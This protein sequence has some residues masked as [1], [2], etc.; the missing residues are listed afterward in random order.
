M[1]GYLLPV[2]LKPVNRQSHPRPPII[3]HLW[4]CLAIGALAAFGGILWPPLLSTDITPETVVVIYSV[5][6]ALTT[7]VVVTTSRAVFARYR[8]ALEH[9]ASIAIDRPL[10]SPAAITTLNH[11][12]WI[13]AVVAAVALLGPM[14]YAASEW[15]MSARMGLAVGVAVAIS[16]GVWMVLAARTV[17]YTNIFERARVTAYQRGVIASHERAAREAANRRAGVLAKTLAGQ[18]LSALTPLSPGPTL[19]SRG[20]VAHLTMN[21]FYSRL[22][23]G[24]WVDGQQCEVLVTTERLVARTV[25]HGELSFWWSNLTAARAHDLGVE[26]HY[27]SSD[28]IS[29]CGPDTALI[30]VYASHLPRLTL[31]R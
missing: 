1:L 31:D 21:V 24:E 29:L 18:G 8:R 30:S 13:L 11:V 12:Q 7:V 23:Y 4:W 17:R 9:R 2:R 22:D 6:L 25:T 15:T 16:C 20:E 3:T 28:P 27:D 14:G 26:L 5:Q 19:L 10:A